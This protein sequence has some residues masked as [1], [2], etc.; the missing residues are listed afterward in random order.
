MVDMFQ[1]P[2][3]RH[4]N[5]MNSTSCMMWFQRVTEVNEVENDAPESNVVEGGPAEVKQVRQLHPRLTGPD[6]DPA[7][8]Q[9]VRMLQKITVPLP[10]SETRECSQAALLEEINTV[11]PI[12]MPLKDAL[13][14]VSEAESAIQD[15]DRLS[16]LGPDDG[17]DAHNISIDPGSPK[18]ER[19]QK[20][21]LEER[22]TAL[23]TFIPSKDDL[24]IGQASRIQDIPSL[25][26]SSPDDDLDHPSIS[27][28]RG[29][30]KDDRPES[31]V[32]QNIKTILSKIM[33]SKDTTNTRQESMIPSSDMMSNS[34]CKENLY[35]LHVTPNPGRSKHKN[36]KAKLGH[37]RGSH[38]SHLHQNISHTTV[39]PEYRWEWFWA[40]VGA[41]ISA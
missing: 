29:Y 15:T 37:R 20:T 6:I 33:S 22:N 38:Q 10:S 7:A 36:W 32:L 17:S 39:S 40:C 24:G 19:S 1:S 35:G 23:P 11:S 31:I 21:T 27:A 16:T 13:E 18:H 28:E 3:Q 4:T 30:T 34:S 5:G 12:S 41:A 9:R 26:T 25:P 14:P 2:Y 8:F